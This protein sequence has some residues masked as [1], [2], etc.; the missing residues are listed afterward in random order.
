MYKYYFN[1]C[2]VVFILY[3]FVFY[4][5]ICNFL[6]LCSMYMLDIKMSSYGNGDSFRICWVRKTTKPSANLRLSDIAAVDVTS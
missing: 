5:F 6:N 1:F 3:L 4:L 2:C